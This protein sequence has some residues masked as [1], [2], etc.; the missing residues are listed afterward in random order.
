MRCSDGKKNGSRPSGVRHMQQDKW[1]AD[2]HLTR[3]ADTTHVCRSRSS[4]PV[5]MGLHASL[6]CHKGM[7]PV[8]PGKIQLAKSMCDEAGSPCQRCLYLLSE[9]AGAILRDRTV[10]I[11]KD[12]NRRIRLR[13]QFLLLL[14]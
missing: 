8:E 13:L 14:R 4:A 11:S 9:S 1:L 10:G 7:S 6:A 5:R 12:R 3:L 2:T